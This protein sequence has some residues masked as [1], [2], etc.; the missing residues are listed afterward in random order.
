MVVSRRWASMIFSGL[1]SAV[2]LVAGASQV[3]AAPSNS[4]G[5][6]VRVDAQGPVDVRAD[7]VVFEEATKTYVAEGEVEVVRGS[8]KIFA[9]RVRLHSEK[10][11]AE[12]EGRTRMEN[13]SEVL[14]GQRLLIDL[15]GGTGKVY[16][17]QIFIKSN[18]FYMRGQEIDKVGKESYH[19]QSGSLT[20]CYGPSPSWNISGRD[21]DVDLDGFGTISGAAFRIQDVPVLYSPWATF[22][23]K[24]RRQSGL[25]PP[26]VGMS[27][28]DGVIWSQPWYQTLGEDQDVTL[29]LNYM[30]YRG[31]DYGLEYRYS[32]APGSKGM[33]ALDCMP[34]D[35]MGQELK[36]AEAYESRY[37][38]RMKSDQRLSS[39]NMNLKMDIDL[40]SDQNY[41]KEF[42]FGYTGFEATKQRFVEAVGR[43]LDPRTSTWRQNKVNLQRYWSNA[44]FNGSLIYNDD[45]ASDNKRIQ[46]QLPY[47]SFDATRQPVGETG[48]YFQM[49]S[50]Y[51]Y[52]YQQEGATGH[53]SDISPTFALPL[54]FNDYL[55]MNLGSPISSVSTTSPA[56]TSSPTSLVP[57][58]P[59]LWNFTAQTSTY[60]PGLRVRHVRGSLE[61]QA[62]LLPLRELLLPA[63]HTRR[64]PALA[65]SPGPKPAG[66]QPGCLRR[67][68][69]PDQQ[70]HHQ[71]R[72]YRRGAPRLSGILHLPVGARLQP[73]RV[74][75]RPHQWRPRPPVLGQRGSALGHLSQQIPLH[76]GRRLLEPI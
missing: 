28:C 13:D 3:A 48:W 32:L 51:N 59:A 72:P 39:D 66:G 12:A 54:N 55:S 40:V 53:I 49:G 30:S 37:W 23:A 27:D 64:R 18:N 8:T 31:L 52:Y 46:Q 45:L 17:G 15:Q 35:A 21:I 47:L 19:L 63:Q 41:L 11:V 65:D 76:G 43:E 10:L 50:S 16:D 56:T 44:T 61:A 42:T 7:R 38:F 26:M 57:P 9:D 33:M 34:E 73:K 5:Q 24:F 68:E 36:N 4:P 14:T 6:L 69:H 22:P 2:L 29:I 71:G 58:A 62:R 74:P 60:V 75:Q 25:L 1:L 67:A 20:S 70:A